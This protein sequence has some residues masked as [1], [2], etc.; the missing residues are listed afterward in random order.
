MPSVA[1]AVVQNGEQVWANA[2]GAADYDEEREATP[3]TQYRIGS[4]TKTFTATAVMQ[5]RD[6]GLLEL[7][8]RVDEHLAELPSRSPT[9]RRLLAHARLKPPMHT[10]S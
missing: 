10:S 3:D 4:V 9:I 1:A 5:L 7:D 8:D 2:V 6:A